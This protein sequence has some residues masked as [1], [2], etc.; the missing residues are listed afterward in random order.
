LLQSILIFHRLPP[1]VPRTGA[2]VHRLIHS[3]AAAR[4]GGCAP[5]RSSAR[6][7][8]RVSWPP[9]GR[10]S[11]APPAWRTS[12]PTTISR[13]GH[14]ALPRSPPDGWRPLA[15]PSSSAPDWSRPRCSRC[16]S[17]PP[18]RSPE[19]GPPWT[20]YSR[21]PVPRCRRRPRP[22]ARHRRAHHRDSLISCLA[23]VDL[24]FRWG[25]GRSTPGRP[26]R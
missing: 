12:G 16:P 14:A 6:M 2:V 25:P 22:G 7:L 4:C 26:A 11:R 21:R 17:W 18:P 15:P 5:P 10:C 19:P 23:T 1:V 13:T 9:Q 8:R 20:T 24:P 3:P